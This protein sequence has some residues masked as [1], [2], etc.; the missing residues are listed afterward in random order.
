VEPTI[1][2]DPHLVVPSPVCALPGARAYG[3]AGSNRARLRSPAD[4]LALA[5]LPRLGGVRPPGPG[6]RLLAELRRLA[7]GMS[8]RLSRLRSHCAGRERQRP[9]AAGEGL[10]RQGSDPHLDTRHGDA[11]RAASA[12]GA[13]GGPACGSAFRRSRPADGL[14]AAGRHGRSEHA[15]ERG[16]GKSAMTGPRGG[17]APGQGSWHASA[18]RSATTDPRRAAPLQPPDCPSAVPLLAATE[19]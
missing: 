2:L 7:R 3:S 18:W 11:G 17:P 15:R 5:S 10:R 16:A 1:E 9:C 14:S 4:D 6:R 13:R 19:A 8:L 12:R